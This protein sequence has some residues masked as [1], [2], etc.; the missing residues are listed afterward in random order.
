M[1]KRKSAK[2]G[3]N[4]GSIYKRKDGR[5]TS[6]LNLGYQD[7]KLKRKSFYGKTRDDV[8][9]KLTK[10]LHDHQQSLPVAIPRQSVEQFFE[11]WLSDCVK[12]KV[13][14]KT[15]ASYSQ[16]VNLH[17]KPA[18]GS[19]TLTEVA[20]RACSSILKTIGSL[21]GQSARMRQTPRRGSH[22]ALFSI[23][24]LFLGVPWGR[25]TS[26]GSLRETWPRWSI[27]HA[28]S[29]QRYVR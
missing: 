13:R 14:P 17:I 25:R 6:V 23:C 16:L 1:S 12:P 19:L 24:V 20:T 5:W 29:S 4:E 28:L 21:Q 22:R 10:A 2:R 9:K 27:R 7:G 11:R 8:R 3:Q 15:F 18:T 26:G